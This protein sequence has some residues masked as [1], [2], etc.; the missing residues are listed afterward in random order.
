MRYHPLC[1][2]CLVSLVIEGWLS[3]FLE[4]FLGTI[5]NIAVFLRQRYLCTNSFIVVLLTFLHP[6]S[7]LKSLPAWP[8][9]PNQMVSCLY[10]VMSTIMIEYSIMVWD[11]WYDSIFQYVIVRMRSS[12]F[13]F[14]LLVYSQCALGSSLCISVIN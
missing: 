10:L 13:S 11:T 6:T 8:V 1:G 14:F 9:V 5:M 3:F 7:N 2:S 4:T 12:V